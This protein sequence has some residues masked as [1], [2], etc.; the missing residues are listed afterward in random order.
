MGVGSWTSVENN[1]DSRTT[2]QFQANEFAFPLVEFE[3]DSLNNPMKANF[4]K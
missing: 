2:V 4:L 3:M 1:S